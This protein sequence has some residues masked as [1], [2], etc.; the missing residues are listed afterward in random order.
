MSA[1]WSAPVDLDNCAA[2]P[3]HIPGAIQPHGVLLA[4]TEPEL[5]VVVASRNVEDWF[6]VRAAD[7]IGADV[8]TVIGP[9]NRDTVDGA[10][11]DDWVQR[12][13]DVAL[14][15]GERPHVGTLYRSGGLLVIEIEP[16]E[17]A[18]PPATVMREAA[19]ALQ[20]AP[21][22]AEVAEAAARWVRS[23]TGF[24][25]VMV[26]RFDADW[27]GEV[28]AEA[29]REDL[30]SFLGLHYPSTDIPAQARE[31]Y[32]RNWIRLI[33]DVAYEPV[34]LEPSSGYASERPLDLSGSTLRSVSPIHIEYLTNMGVSA[35]MSMSIVIDGELWGLIACHH[36]SG[37]HRPGVA[38][39]N[40]A[41]YLAQLISLRTA[42]TAEADVRRRTLEL[43]ALADHV[44]DA[45]RSPAVEDL[46]AALHAEEA[47]V[48][49]LARATGAIVAAE[50]TWCRLGSTPAD[51]VVRTIL[52]RWPA[53]EAVFQVDQLG[54]GADDV[55]SGVLAYQ[56]TNDRREFVMWFRPELVRQVDWGGDPHNA[57]IAREEGDEIRLSPRKSFDRW[58]ETVRGHSEP[59]HES[60][61]RAATRFVRHLTAGLLRR[62]RDHAE[63]AS[64]LQRAMR[65]DLPP[66]VPGWTF[67]AHYETAGS[68]EIGGDWWDVFDAGGGQ[69]VAVVGDVAGHGLRAAAEMAQLRN[70]LRAYLLDDPA[71]ARALE[72]LDAAMSRVLPGTI[73][74][75]ICAVLDTATATVH[76]SH[77]GHMPALVGGEGTAEFVVVK[78]DLLLGVSPGPRREHV[79]QLGRG[80]VLVLYSDGLVERRN[81]PID[82]G[83]ALLRD[84]VADATGAVVPDGALATWIAER[85]RT[86]AHE[87]DVSVLVIRHD[88]TAP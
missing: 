42:E 54:A 87:D 66:P 59:W 30:N 77:A 24:D 4:V 12:R 63:I 78:P 47:A 39:R 18:D 83:L 53:G 11:R 65:P 14:T 75:A 55:A 56:L 16:V 2:E 50:E 25:R 33:P 82:D 20:V 36:Y 6:G 7:V 49:G 40:A 13:D 43:V 76:L 1:T 37:P 85:M 51:A 44:A 64:D 73:A 3:I 32:R 17:A 26:Y 46:D 22:V 58:R 68:G 23:L 8:G 19:M 84:V 41:E 52:D 34:E 79:I 80:Q 72:R 86:D 10:R 81:R 70:I 28:I 27:H 45:V 29:R 71:P 67:D 62:Q 60:E 9:A 5:S 61:L 21:T 74:T 48:L 31:L 88:V 38:T 69:I 35:S 15:V 57:K